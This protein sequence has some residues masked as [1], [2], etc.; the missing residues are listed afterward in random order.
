M[1]EDRGQDF[2]CESF[3]LSETRVDGSNPGSPNGWRVRVRLPSNSP[4]ATID[5]GNGVTVQAPASIEEEV[6]QHV[7]PTG[8]TYTVCV[9]FEGCPKVFCYTSDQCRGKA[10]HNNEDWRMYTT[11]I[12]G[13][14]CGKSKRF[15]A[16]ASWNFTGFGITGHMY[17]ENEENNGNGWRA[18]KARTISVSNVTSYYD[19]F[20]LP[21]SMSPMTKTETNKKRVLHNY[22]I[23]IP[24][25]PR[26]PLR[27]PFVNL[28][29][30]LGQSSSFLFNNS[31]TDEYV[32]FCNTSAV[33]TFTFTLTAYKQ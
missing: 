16:S 4:P 28:S 1:V 22:V 19:S 5:W 32:P 21:F 15:H 14:S 17:C 25:G 20:C 10:N 31:I 29:A 9:R 12:S 7:Y 11:P 23:P 18:R 33:G 2:D 13:T 3:G 26:P 24:L 6:Y 30:N 27:L 8:G